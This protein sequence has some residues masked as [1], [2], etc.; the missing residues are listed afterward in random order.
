MDGED[1]TGLSCL[2]FFRGCDRVRVRDRVRAYLGV[3][4]RLARI[5]CQYFTSQSIILGLGLPSPRQRLIVGS[6][7]IPRRRRRC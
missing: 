3:G 6:P 5:R 4:D 1:L 2:F 7:Q